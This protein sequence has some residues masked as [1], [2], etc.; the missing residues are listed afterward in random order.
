M[1]SYGDKYTYLVQMQ[2]SGEREMRVAAERIEELGLAIQSTDRASRGAGTAFAN[3]AGGLGQFANLVEDAQFGARAITNNLGGVIMALGGFTPV[4]IAAGGAVQLLSVAFRDQI[5]TFL[6]WVGILDE[7]LTPSAKKTKEEV[8]GITKA[9]EGLRDVAPMMEGTAAALKNAFTGTLGGLDDQAIV[10]KLLIN[11]ETL[12]GDLKQAEGQVADAGAQLR[13]RLLTTVQ[14]RGHL[15]AFS[16]FVGQVLF[17]GDLSEEAEKGL[18]EARERQVKLA[19]DGFIALVKAAATSDEKLEELV[20]RLRDI[21]EATGDLDAFKQADALEKLTERYAKATAKADL[22]RIAT[23]K[24]ADAAKKLTDELA[25]QG[26]ENERLTKKLDEEADKRIE[27]AQ[28][29]AEAKAK[30]REAE[31]NQD[32]G[33]TANA[34]RG[35]LG[36]RIDAGMSAM[37]GRGAT[38][39]QAKQA[40]FVDTFNQMRRAGVGDVDAANAA[41]RLVSEQAAMLEQLTANMDA[42]LGLFEAQF[43]DG[44]VA[45]RQAEIQAQRIRQFQ[46]MQRAQNPWR[47]NRPNGL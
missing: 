46:L 3:M 9:V 34:F 36:G 25:K 37:M 38:L 5:D 17:G 28:R 14:D 15:A 22:F 41:E 39:D 35:L 42:M 1:P 6:E 32:A 16:E 31:Q 23:D 45:R 11:N 13:D 29:E 24:N 10:N 8:E 21:G 4:S 26:E 44:T 43:R 19:K 30:I 2:T 27:A 47:N 7:N 20:K 12:K 18:N 40:A 33:V